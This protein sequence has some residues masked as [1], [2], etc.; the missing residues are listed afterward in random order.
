MSTE[1]IYAE[2]GCDEKELYNKEP[3]YQQYHDIATARALV[4]QS[5]CFREYAI[6]YVIVM[7]WCSIMHSV[8]IECNHLAS[9]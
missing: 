6:N 2:E 4:A 7:L 9:A 1:G 5:S 3:L 8:C